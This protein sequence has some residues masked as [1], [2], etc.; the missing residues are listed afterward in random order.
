MGPLT[1]PGIIVGLG[2]LLY[3][4]RLG[5]GASFGR[6]LAVHLVVCVPYAVRI[7][8]PLLR[9]ALFSAAVFVFLVS[10]DETTITFLL[11]GSGYVT[12]PVHIFNQLT[13]VWDPTISAISTVMMVVTIGAVLLLDRFV[14]LG[15][16]R[17]V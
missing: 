16:L 8:L 3:F 14:G 4:Q 13:Q 5:L 1:V 9:A 10:F 6:L 17:D 12:P 11:A 2:S 7:I 15:R